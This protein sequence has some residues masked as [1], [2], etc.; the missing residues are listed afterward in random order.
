MPAVQRAGRRLR[1]RLAGHAG[2]SA[3]ATSGC[4]PARRCGPRGPTSPTSAC[5]LARTDP[6]VP[7]AQG[8]HL[9]PRRPAR[10]PASRCGRCA[11]SPA[12]STSTRCSSTA[13]GCP[14]PTG[15]A[16]VG[17]G[18][19]VA[20]ATLSGERQMVSGS[21]SGGV[22]RIGGSGA[23]RAHRA[24]ARAPARGT[25]RSCASELMRAVQ[26]GAD[27]RLDEPAGAGRPAG[28]PL[29]RARELDRQGAPGRAQPA[30]PAA[31]RRPARRRRHGLGVGRG[32][33]TTSRCPTR[34]AGMLRSRAN[35]IE[36]G[37]TE[38]NKN[39]VGER[40]LGL[41]REPDPWQRRAVARGPAVS[42]GDLRDAASS[43]GAGRSAGWSSTGPTPATPWTPR[44]SPSSSGRGASST[45]TPTSG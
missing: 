37:T 10:S 14:T 30:H 32:R 17:D 20:N 29:A 35:T 36:G 38:V 43:S 6:D 40:V 3:T 11:T 42:D 21:G 9:L 4:S 39:I 45:P 12:R 24:G 13:S 28:R 22:D 2:P 41:P 26:R 34:C 25:T 31:R 44:C 1:P 27:P 18:W 8:H 19:R 7:E 23:D 33:P 15:S 5:C 16:T